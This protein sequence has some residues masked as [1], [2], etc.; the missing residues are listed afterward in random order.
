MAAPPNKNPGYSTA[1]VYRI[2]NVL[3]QQ[4]GNDVT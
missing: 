3:M 2:Q 4:Y 1:D